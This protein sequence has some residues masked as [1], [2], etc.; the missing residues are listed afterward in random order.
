M[1][2]W[3]KSE[4]EKMLFLEIATLTFIQSVKMEELRLDGTWTIEPNWLDL[5][6]LEKY[7]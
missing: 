7:L 5:M 6:V 3:L 2:G 4:S 1:V